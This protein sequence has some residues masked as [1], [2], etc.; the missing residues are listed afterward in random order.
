MDV[1]G[2]VEGRLHAGRT[3]ALRFAAFGGPEVLE[4]LDVPTPRPGPDEALVRVHAASINPSDVKN[5]AGRM[6]QTVPPRTPGRDFAGTVVAGPAEWIGTEVWGTGG[7][8]GYTRDGTHARH[9]VVPAAALRRKP[10][11]LSFEEAGAVGVNYVTAWLGL[12]E[13]ALL[14]PGETV[15]VFGATGGVGGAVAALARWHGARVVACCRGPLP[16]DSVAAQVGAEPLDLTAAGDLPAALAALTGGKGF[17][18]VYD[19]V[20][21]PALFSAG[22]GALGFRGRYVAIAGSPGEAVSLELIP[23]YRKEARL[24]GIDSLKRGVVACAEVMERLARGFESGALPAPRIAE[25]YTLDEAREAY[26]AV[27]NGT[28]GRVILT[29]G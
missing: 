1:A 24:L 9:V 8:I 23:F 2:E 27:A 25:A 7:D 17:D 28:R 14:Q 26:A 15:L 4:T 21:T 3:R 5:V 29:M 20:G 18:V 13:A 16:A 22:V 11:R 12:H 19:T 10:E 6:R